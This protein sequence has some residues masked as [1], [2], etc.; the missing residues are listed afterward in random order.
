[1]AFISL[2]LPDAVLGVAWPQMRIDFGIPLDSLGLISI[3]V[4]GF[5]ILSSLLS[6]YLIKTLGT[7]KVTYLSILLTA[8]ALIGISFS[9]SFIWVVI[10]SIPLGFGAGSID[11]ALNNYVAVHYKSHHMNWLHAFWGVGATLGPIVISTFFLL[12]Y[13]WRNGYM[14]LGITQAV[15]LLIVL[16]SGKLWKRNLQ[17]TE[18]RINNDDVTYKEVL[19]TKGVI[20]AMTMFVVYCAIEFGVGNWGASY[21]VSER[22]IL[23]GMAGTM[24][25]TY[26]AGITIGR[27]ISG[28]VSFKFTNKQL[29]VTGIIIL[30]VASFGLLFPVPIYLLFPLFFLQGIGLAPIFPSLIHETPKRFTERK[31]QHVIGLQMASAYVGASVIPAIFGVVARYSS[32][33]LYPYFIVGLGVIM[34]FVNQT[35]NNKTKER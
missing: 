2:G 35:L 17:P 10:L 26:Y 31:S 12:D 15:I 6:G 33:G 21:L 30:I 13:S 9:P 34:L 5:T 19:Q 22:T 20:F 1:M 11:T 32:L 23:K 24:I 25:G 7:H 3:A 14:V 18:E 29:I 16:F 28:F 8:F 27:I 4:T